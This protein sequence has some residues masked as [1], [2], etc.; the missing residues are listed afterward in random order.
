[1]DAAVKEILWL[2]KNSKKCWISELVIAGQG[3][4]HS[5]QAICS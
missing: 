1:M 5:R 3:A 4:A 2:Q